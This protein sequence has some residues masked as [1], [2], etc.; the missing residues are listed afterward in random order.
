MAA[1]RFVMGKEA[2]AS[3]GSLYLAC[4]VK[5]GVSSR[6]EGIISVSDSRI[7]ICVRARAKDGEANKAVGDLIADASSLPPS[8]LNL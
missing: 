7:E 6:R 1:V 3:V 5:P 8:S 4:H 2:R